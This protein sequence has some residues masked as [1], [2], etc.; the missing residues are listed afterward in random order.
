MRELVLAKG[1]S[2]VKNY[3]Y[4]KYKKSR[5][6]V[7]SESSLI[8]TDKRVI[9]EVKSEKYVSRQEM[10]ITAVD[11]VNCSIK[12][13]SRSLKATIISA[14]LALVFLVG[15]ITFNFINPIQ[16][17]DS[18]IPSYVCYGFGLVAIL[19]SVS[20][21]AVWI[22]SCGCSV[23]VALLSYKEKNALFG[24]S[25]K[26]HYDAL[27]GLPKLKME[28]DRE[29]ADQMVEELSAVI[30]TIKQNA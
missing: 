13:Q 22:K 19:L 5:R 7:E 30:F 14:I 25:I 3:T 28:V 8:V 15:G 1:E 26:N 4:V 24:A 29:V 17:L 2:I 16:G 11:F 21:F 18:A 12:N 23:S 27:D 20:A 10:P 9:K 6:K